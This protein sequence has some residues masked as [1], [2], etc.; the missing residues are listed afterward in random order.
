MAQ[1]V[2]RMKDRCEAS[3][4][5]NYSIFAEIFGL[6]IG[7]PLQSLFRL[8]DRNSVREALKVFGQTALVRASIKPLR[9]R[10]GVG[11]WESGVSGISGQFDNSFRPKHT[12]QMLVQKH[13]RKAL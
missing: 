6:F 7:D 8:H 5:V 4:E 11:C 3:L 1:S 12:I 2:L 9:Q 10:M 13:F